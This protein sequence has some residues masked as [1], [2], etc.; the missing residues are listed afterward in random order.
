MREMCRTPRFACAFSP[1]WRAAGVHPPRCGVLTRTRRGAKVKVYFSAICTPMPIHN[2]SVNQRGINVVPFPLVASSQTKYS[3]P[4]TAAD[5]RLDPDPGVYPAQGAR[6]G[7]A[8]SIYAY[9]YIEHAPTARRA[10]F[11]VPSRNSPS[12]NLPRTMKTGGSGVRRE[13][14]CTFKPMH[15]RASTTSPPREPKPNSRPRP[16]PRSRAP[17]GALRAP[18]SQ[19]RTRPPPP[20]AQL[21]RANHA[22]QLARSLRPTSTPTSISVNQ[23]RAWSTVYY[24][25][26]VVFPIFRRR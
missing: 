15:H 26:C 23:R 14:P 21:L 12:V 2:V 24:R 16:R 5:G 4:R 3:A 22:D 20:L 17:H 6:Q 18:R 8:A 11:C 19:L 9:E 13:C 25:A 1:T 10:K 7:P